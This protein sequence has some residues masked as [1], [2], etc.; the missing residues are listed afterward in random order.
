MSGPATQCASCTR[1]ASPIDT[2]SDGAKLQTCTPFPDGIPLD[3][4]FMRFDH[5][6]PYPGDRGLLYE[7]LPGASFPEYALDDD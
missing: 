4:W 1:W 6:K 5:R 2:G 3:I 7:A